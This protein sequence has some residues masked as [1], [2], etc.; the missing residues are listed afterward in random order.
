VEFRVPEFD[1]DFFDWKKLH[2]GDAEYRNKLRSALNDIK[3]SGRLDYLYSWYH[4]KIPPHV[5]PFSPFLQ[6]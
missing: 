4:P 1:V 3:F 5:R 6:R 2:S